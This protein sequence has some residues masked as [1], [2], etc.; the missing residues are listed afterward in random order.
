MNILTLDT[1]STACS[2]AL[3][4]GKE[5]K[6]LHTIAPMQQAK[7]ILPMIH[8]LLE[9]FALT[10]EDLDLIAYGGGPGSFTG[11]RIAN[12]V[13]Q[14]FGLGAQK[15]IIRISSLAA[16]AQA[17]FL[18]YGHNEVL[19]AVDARMEQIYWAS[20]KVMA[21]GYMELV[22]QELLCAPEDITIP[23]G[24]NWCGVGDGWEKYQESLASKLDFKPYPIHIQPLP[25]AH[26]ILQLAKIE[27]ELGRQF[28]VSD[29]V[30]VY[31]R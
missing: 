15:P 2:L 14:G 18:E 6:T 25:T 28:T 7:L 30:P 26:A 27:F 13:A 22:D 31:L 23:T 16:L 3:Q 9:S 10:P 11:I 24:K 20:Y 5:L 21:R 29:A 8:E 12:S 19:V 1:S 17:A 4:K